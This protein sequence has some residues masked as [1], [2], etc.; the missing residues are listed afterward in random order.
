[1]VKL[2]VSLV[3]LWRT[4]QYKIKTMYFYYIIIKI[5]VLV[6]INIYSHIYFFE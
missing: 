5:Y 4:N 1:M 6:C 2:A 3:P